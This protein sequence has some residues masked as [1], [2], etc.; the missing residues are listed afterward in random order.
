MH[1]VD[2]NCRMVGD[3]RPVEGAAQA[4]LLDSDFTRPRQQQQQL[5]RTNART[6]LVN[7]RHPDL[8]EQYGLQVPYIMPLQNN[9][10]ERTVCIYINCIFVY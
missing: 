2:E 7:Q 3:R 5:H 10:Y 1:Q 9:D 8:A 6:D 4:R